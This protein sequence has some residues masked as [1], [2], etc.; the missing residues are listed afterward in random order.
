MSQYLNVDGMNYMWA[1]S[2]RGSPARLAC[3]DTYIKAEINP[4]HATYFYDAMDKYAETGHPY[5][6]AASGE[7]MDMLGKYC[8]LV[9]TGEMKVEDAIA[10]MVKEGNPKLAAAAA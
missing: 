3:K 9:R 1:A 4:P 6:T 7:V 2:G 8:G 5:H 10:T